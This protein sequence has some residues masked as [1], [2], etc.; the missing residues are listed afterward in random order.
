MFPLKIHKK[1]QY[2]MPPSMLNFSKKSPS[3][4]NINSKSR[5]PDNI[6]TLINHKSQDIHPQIKK[7]EKF[8]I[9]LESV[10]TKANEKERSSVIGK[11][12]L[13]SPKSIR[14]MKE[15][16]TGVPARYKEINFKQ[17][18]ASVA[19]LKKDNMRIKRDLKIL[20]INDGNDLKERLKIAKLARQYEEDNNIEG[21]LR[22]K[23]FEESWKWHTPGN[24]PVNKS[25]HFDSN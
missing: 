9:K 17:N 11:A 2:T 6:Q 12:K 1:K 3:Y 7:F 25:V 16:L 15:K 23:V 22:N 18:S 14:S 10:G 4:P 20:R 19:S 21:I 5:S 13:S 24:T 8:L